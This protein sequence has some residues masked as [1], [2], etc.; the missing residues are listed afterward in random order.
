MLIVLVFYPEFLIFSWGSGRLFLCLE[1][2]CVVGLVVTDGLCAAGMF[3]IVGPL[4][5]S[6]LWYYGLTQGQIQ[7]YSHYII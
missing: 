6:L 2:V 3:R 5:L 1:G 7:I 4:S